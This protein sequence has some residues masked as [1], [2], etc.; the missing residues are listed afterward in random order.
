MKFFVHVAGIGQIIIEIKIFV[1]INVEREFALVAHIDE[2]AVRKPIRSGPVRRGERRAPG[3]QRHRDGVEFEV[4]RLLQSEFEVC[5]R[6]VHNDVR[7]RE[8][9]QIW[10]RNLENSDIFCSSNLSF[11]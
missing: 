10:V 6:P 8:V 1:L 4:L 9:Q 2:H 7:R 5:G 3:P 11:I